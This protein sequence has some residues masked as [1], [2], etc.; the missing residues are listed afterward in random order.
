MIHFINYKLTYDYHGKIGISADSSAEAE[1]I[2]KLMKVTELRELSSES[3]HRV[4][5][6]AD[7]PV[8][9]RQLTLFE[10]ETSP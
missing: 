6:K 4:T 10:D 3:E 5:A 8:D 7:R 9:L 1:E 2:V